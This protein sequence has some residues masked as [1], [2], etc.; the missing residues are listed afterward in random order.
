MAAP[1]GDADQALRD[2]VERARVKAAEWR[3][4]GVGEDLDQPVHPPA[5]SALLATYLTSYLGSPIEPRPAPRSLKGRV[6]EKLLGHDRAKTDRLFEYAKLLTEDL[7]KT[8]CRL[9]VELAELRARVGLL[10]ERESTRD[11]EQGRS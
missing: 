2:L 5:Q 10:E 1:G 6:A 4:R 9:E 7:A 11:F 3:G 8:I